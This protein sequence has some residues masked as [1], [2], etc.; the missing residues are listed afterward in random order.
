MPKFVQFNPREET[1]DDYI[2][3]FEI[4][5]KVNTVKAESKVD[6]LLH[7]IWK[8]AYD[9]LKN[10]LQPSLPQAKTYDE[11]AKELKRHCAPSRLI[12]AART[13][14]HLRQQQDGESITD[15]VVAIKELSQTCCFEAFLNEALRYRLLAECRNPEIQRSLL[16]LD[17]EG[18]DE[19]NKNALAKELSMQETRGMQQQPREHYSAD[20]HA[21]QRRNTQQQSVPDE[22][23][24]GL[25]L[26]FPSVFHSGTGT[27]KDYEAT[28]I[29]K[30]SC[31]PVFP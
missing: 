15:F 2:E 16:E 11:L 12:T 13:K 28:L 10:I 14:F 6:N 24:E 4:F 21:V 23:V 1:I 17:N 22:T 26:A 8:E 3:R 27:I 9:T 7:Y 29:V 19:V 30:P 20:V 25:K 31:Q 5:L 18:F